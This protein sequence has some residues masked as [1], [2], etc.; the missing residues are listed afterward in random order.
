MAVGSLWTW[1]VVDDAGLATRTFALIGPQLVFGVGIGMVLAPLINFVVSPV[2]DA[3]VG[4]A[5]G[6]FNSAQQLAS[7]AGVAVLGTVFFTV[8][9]HDG[10]VSA[11][12]RCLL[13]DAGLAAALFGLT[14]LL[15]NRAPEVIDA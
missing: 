2:R 14:Y 11:Y 4:S 1:Q 8:L 15:P 12:G 7:A 6:V 9:S 5:T 10:F 13:I 3:E